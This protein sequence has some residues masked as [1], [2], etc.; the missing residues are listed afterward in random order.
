MNH[1]VGSGALD[2]STPTRWFA[3][4]AALRLMRVYD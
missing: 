4:G 1:L 2:E 3:A